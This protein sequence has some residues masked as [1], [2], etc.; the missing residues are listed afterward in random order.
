MERHLTGLGDSRCFDG[1]YSS[2]ARIGD[3]SVLAEPIEAIGEQVLKLERVN[4]TE[5]P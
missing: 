4:G 1:R 3:C 2:G 5:G